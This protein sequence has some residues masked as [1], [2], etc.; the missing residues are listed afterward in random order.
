M[1]NEGLFFFI[2]YLFFN[3]RKISYLS[4]TIITIVI[5]KDND[6]NIIYGTSNSCVWIKFYG[7]NKIKIKNKEKKRVCRSNNHVA[8]CVLELENS[9]EG[10][11]VESL[12]PTSCLLKAETSSR[13]SMIPFHIRFFFFFFILTSL[14]LSLSSAT[15]PTLP[16]CTN[17]RFTG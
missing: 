9:L 15:K 4:L 5:D 13:C 1:D 6:N 11:S 10:N 12:K 2:Q 16:N 14:R 7:I 17:D 8:H 3:Q